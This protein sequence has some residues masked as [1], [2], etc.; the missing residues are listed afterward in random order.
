MYNEM[1]KSQ[2]NT[3]VLTHVSKD[4]KSLVGSITGIKESIGHDVQGSYRDIWSAVAEFDDMLNGIDL[5]NLVV[6]VLAITFEF[7]TSIG[8]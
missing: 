8:A 6:S 1:I 7:V 5:K 2:K 4:L 3:P